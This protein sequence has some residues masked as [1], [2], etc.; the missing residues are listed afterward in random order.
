[1]ADDEVEDA[2]VW[3]LQK[4][5]RMHQKYKSLDV[6]SRHVLKLDREMLAEAPLKCIA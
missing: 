1:M 5:L 3:K 6:L 2:E 4:A